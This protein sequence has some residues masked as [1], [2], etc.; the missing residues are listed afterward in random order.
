MDL[1]CKVFRG[2]DHGALE[3]EINRFLAEELAEDSEVQLEEITQSEGPSGRHHHALVLQARA[4]RRAASTSSRASIQP[5][6]SPRCASATSSC[7]PTSPTARRRRFDTALDL[8][9]DSG[10]RITLFH[11]HHVPASV[12]PDVH[13]ADRARAHAQRRALGRARAR[14]VARPRARDAGIDADVSTTFGATADEICRTAEELGVDLI[15]IGTH[16]RGGLS[17]VLLGSVA[18]KVV[19]KAPCP[20]L[21]VRPH[22]HSTFAHT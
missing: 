10:A 5:E 14:Q 12:F 19:R 7:R 13:P 2:P 22:M 11:V 4:R 17:H 15:V 1:R 18:E 9:R 16:G 8:A 20:V 6:I 21:T 3:E